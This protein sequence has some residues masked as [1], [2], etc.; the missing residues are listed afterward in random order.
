MP[1]PAPT[2]TPAPQLRPRDTS[3]LPLTTI[4]TPPS[5]CLNAP[6]TLATSNSGLVGF[7]SAWRDSSETS[8]KCY[9][10]SFSPLQ[11]N[12]SWYSPGVCPSGWQV[13]QSQ[14]LSKAG[15]QLTQAWCCPATMTISGASISDLN[16]QY[17]TSLATDE[18]VLSWQSG[19]YVSATLSSSFLALQWPLSVQWASSDLA[20]FRPASAPILQVSATSDVVS[21]ASSAAVGAGVT[22]KPSAHTLMTTAAAQ[23][24]KDLSTGA[25]AGIGLAAAVVIACATAALMF[26][27][28]KRRLARKRSLDA[29]SQGKPLY[30]DTKVEL[31]H[32]GHEIRPER[33]PVEL[34]ALNS[35]PQEMDAHTKP[36]EIHGEKVSSPQEL[37]GN[38]QGHEAEGHR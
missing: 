9:P 33:P 17:C 18:A 36:T 27:L 1:M 34:A 38:W 8:A 23:P 7:S 31:P 20:F 37:E 32:E 10:S 2:T 4:F 5:S 30:V 15:G 11:Y 25:K 29:A 16:Y 26:W 14:V 12:W 22:S 35:S 13:A 3:V 6:F 21:L 19:S 24:S 28:F